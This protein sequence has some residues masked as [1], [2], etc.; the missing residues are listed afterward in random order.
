ME[1]RVEGVRERRKKGR[2][3]GVWEKEIYHSSQSEWI[4]GTNI[5]KI[6]S[7]HT[8]YFHSCSLEVPL[9]ISVPHYRMEGRAQDTFGKAKEWI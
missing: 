7:F 5:T 1:G 6:N 4:T 9:V 3:L 2:T 8:Q